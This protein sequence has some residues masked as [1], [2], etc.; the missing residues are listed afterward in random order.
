MRSDPVVM[1]VFS[2]TEHNVEDALSGLGL[3]DQI[4]R[5]GNR[6]IA[7]GMINSHQTLDSLS[8]RLHLISIG[9]FYRDLAKF[10]SLS[11]HASLLALKQH[12]ANTTAIARGQA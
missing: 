3:F 8:S 12:I 11:S 6:V 10:Q 1:M 9:H 7:I 5:N 4:Q 2:G